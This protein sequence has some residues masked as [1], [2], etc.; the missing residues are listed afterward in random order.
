MPGG[1][2]AADQLLPERHRAV[3]AAQHVAELGQ[4]DAPFVP[5]LAGHESR[6]REMLE[7]LHRAMRQAG[8]IG[9]DGAAAARYGD[10]VIDGAAEPGVAPGGEVGCHADAAHA[11]AGADQQY[12]VRR[13]MAGADS[14]LVLE[15]MAQRERIAF[16]FHGKLPSA[17][18]RKVPVPETRCV[19]PKK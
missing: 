10:G 1:A 17:A 5:Y 13:L 16:Q 9:A 14:I 19:R 2:V 7:H 12:A 6:Y 11:A 15:E 8:E 3:H 18:G 4:A